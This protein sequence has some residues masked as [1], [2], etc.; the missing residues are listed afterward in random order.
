[1]VPADIIKRII[2]IF[3]LHAVENV[4]HAKNAIK[5]NYLIIK[6]KRYI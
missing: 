1:M 5:L 3:D 6:S 2:G 4:F